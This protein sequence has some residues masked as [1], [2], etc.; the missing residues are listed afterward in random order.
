MEREN[1]VVRFE[2][3]LGSLLYLNG[4]VYVGLNSQATFFLSFVIVRF[5]AL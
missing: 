2:S 4:V 5:N 3:F 1:N